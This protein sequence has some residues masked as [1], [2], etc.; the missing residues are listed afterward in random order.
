MEGDENNDRFVCILFV[1][2]Y[3]SHAFSLL[4]HIFQVI[5]KLKIR[6]IVWKMCSLFDSCGPTYVLV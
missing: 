1:C 3:M 5:Q 4:E 2:H 6:S